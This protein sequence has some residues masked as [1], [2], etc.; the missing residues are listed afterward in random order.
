MASNPKNHDANIAALR[1]RH[2]ALHTFDPRP[3]EGGGG[4]AAG[5]VDAG[6]WLVETHQQKRSTKDFE[7][8]AD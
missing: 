4:A 1:R 8:G 2:P 6:G 5:A 3:R 7:T